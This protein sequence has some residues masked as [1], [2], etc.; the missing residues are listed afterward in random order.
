LSITVSDHGCGFHVSKLSD[1]H[2]NRFGL[3]SIRERMTA[4]GGSFDLQS[5]PGKGTVKH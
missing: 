2:S 4:L 3:L 5:V 1:D